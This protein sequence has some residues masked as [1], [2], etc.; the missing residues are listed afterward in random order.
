[1]PDEYRKLTTALADAL[2]SEAAL[3]RSGY[4]LVDQLGA[5]GQTELEADLAG[6][7]DSLRQSM[8]RVYGVTMSQ[9]DS[10]VPEP[11]AKPEE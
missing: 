2:A 9:L 7:L 8:H 4:A 1:V 5:I 3:I 10:L 11:P 6:S